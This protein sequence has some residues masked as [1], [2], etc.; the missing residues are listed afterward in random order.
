MIETQKNR[1]NRPYCRPVGLPDSSVLT[2]ENKDFPVENTFLQFGKQNVQCNTA[3]PSVRR[4]LGQ[5]L[6]G[7][8]FEVFV[9]REIVMNKNGAQGLKTFW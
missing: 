4:H 3:E 1:L 2:L 9:S 8:R 7:L 6:R 5:E